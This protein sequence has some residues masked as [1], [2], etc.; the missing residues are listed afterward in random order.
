MNP[1]QRIEGNYPPKII[2][3]RLKDNRKKT[4]QNAQKSLK[5]LSGLYIFKLLPLLAAV[6]WLPHCLKLCIASC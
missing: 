2:R 5:A 4:L 3:L 6:R 1:F